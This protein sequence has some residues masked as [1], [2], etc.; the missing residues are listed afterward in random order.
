MLSLSISK[1]EAFLFVPLESEKIY[2][3]NLGKTEQMDP[4]K[5]HQ[6]RMGSRKCQEM[7]NGFICL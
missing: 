1:R 2:L 4:S 6:E 7:A 5:L 3:Q